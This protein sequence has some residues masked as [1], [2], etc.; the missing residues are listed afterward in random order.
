MKMK[1]PAAFF[2][3]AVSPLCVMAQE[4]GVNLRDPF[5]PV[6]YVPQAAVTQETVRVVAVEAPQEKPVAQEEWDKARAAIPRAGG[7]FIGEH[8]V[9]RER[10]DK[11]ILFS[12]TRYA[13]DTICTTNDAVAFTWKIDYISFKTNQYG[14]SPVSA[15][16]LSNE[17]K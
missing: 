7:V 8:P 1:F 16:R 4:G 12:K 15:E 17:S 9:T 11:M 13:G 10:V 3:M 14:L 6:G 2:L 5:W